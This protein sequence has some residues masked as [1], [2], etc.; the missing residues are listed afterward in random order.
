MFRTHFADR[1]DRLIHTYEELESSLAL[2]IVNDDY[3]LIEQL[4]AQH[5]NV[6]SE[7]ISFKFQSSLKRGQMFEFLM[8]GFIET[9]GILSG[10]P[11]GMTKQ[12]RQLSK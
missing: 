2:A 5:K 8:R 6:Q 11:E 4:N 9:E 7:I 10:L 12:F 3:E 1:L